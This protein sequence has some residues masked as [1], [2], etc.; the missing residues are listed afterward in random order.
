MPT[1]AAQQLMGMKTVSGSKCCVDTEQSDRVEFFPATNATGKKVKLD[2]KSQET[3]REN[4]SQ[5]E[6]ETYGGKNG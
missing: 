6:R 5:D 2:N 4:Y 1:V 3:E